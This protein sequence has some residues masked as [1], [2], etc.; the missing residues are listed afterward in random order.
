[1]AFKRTS[2]SALKKQKKE[3]LNLFTNFQ[4]KYRNFKEGS[5]VY[6]IPLGYPMGFSK[7][8]VTE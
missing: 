7:H 8:L 5:D 3:F 6:V 2:F 1:M 4:K